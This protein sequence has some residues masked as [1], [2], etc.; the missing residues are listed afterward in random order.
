MPFT[1]SSSIGR[2]YQA[3]LISD[4]CYLS[5]V[6]GELNICAFCYYMGVVAELVGCGKAFRLFLGL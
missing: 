1:L 4:Q 2:W 5:Q 6:L 3:D